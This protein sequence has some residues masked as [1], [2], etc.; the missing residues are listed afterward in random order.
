MDRPTLKDDTS[1]LSIWAQ[2]P[3]KRRTTLLG[4]RFWTNEWFTQKSV[5]SRRIAYCGYYF[6]EVDLNISWCDLKLWLKTSMR[7]IRPRLRGVLTL[8]IWRI[9]TKDFRSIRLYLWA[10]HL[11]EYALKRN[12]YLW[13]KSW[14]NSHMIPK[15]C[16]EKTEALTCVYWGMT[17]NS[18]VNFQFLKLRNRFKK[19]YWSDFVITKIHIY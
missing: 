18:N 15:H 1:D 17:I 12:R 4:M 5:C 6:N 11:Q 7:T 8:K 13:M 14:Q 9:D 3:T 2:N 10:F 16:M 19:G